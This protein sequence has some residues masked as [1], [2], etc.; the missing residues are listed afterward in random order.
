MANGIVYQNK[1][2]MSKHFGEHL[3]DKSLEVYG[4]K[5]I[6]RIV[7]VRPTNLPE[8]EANEL[9]VDNLFL[10]ED[11]SIAV[12]DYESHY[13]RENIVKYLGYVARIVKRWYSDHGEL[14][15]LRLL[16]IYTADIEPG[17]TLVRYDM[18]SVCVSLDEA[19]L[20]GL[21]GDSIL[22]NIGEKLSQHK[23]I[24][25][26]DVMKLSICPLTYKDDNKKQ[27]A[28]SDAA[29]LA[30]AIEDDSLRTMA[31]AGILAFADKIISDI[32]AEKIRRRLTMTKIEAIYMREMEEAVD[33]AVKEN[34][35]QVTLNLL[36]DLV[37]NGS[38]A[39][40]EAMK[41]MNLS[42]DEF[43]KGLEE[44]RK[45]HPV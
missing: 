18:G 24:T 41:R 27:E 31:L 36:F 26:E 9:K 17:S 28:V 15:K 20:I 29:Q 2:V 1:D 45:N 30:S 38:L 43:G 42:D 35:K 33:A 34:T 10:L 21:D 37:N 39:R 8:V 19:F 13:S 4:F 6:P 12:I 16:I 14:P 3:K 7:D 44:Y 23:T 5:D 22:R 40:E 11:S 25:D 32:D